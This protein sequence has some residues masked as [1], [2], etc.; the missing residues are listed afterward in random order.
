M[1]QLI[2]QH[3]SIETMIQNALLTQY[4]VLL[5]DEITSIFEQVADLLEIQGE[6]YDRIRAYREA[7]HTI[8]GRCLFLS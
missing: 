5:N 8:R 3:K 7:A 1:C 4:V 6:S 2:P